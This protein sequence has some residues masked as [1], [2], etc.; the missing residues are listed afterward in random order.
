MVLPAAAV[1]GRRGLA[2]LLALCLW[3]GGPAAAGAGCIPARPL[4]ETR[5]VGKVA[6]RQPADLVLAGGRLLV[7]DDLNARIAVLDQQGR[8]VGSI[9]L[10]RGGSEPALGI[11]F[12]GADE[13][14]VTAPGRGEIVVLDLKG[15]VLRSFGAGEAGRPGRAA[16]I[17]VTRGTCYVTDNETHRVRF[18]ALDGKVLGGWGGLGEGQRQFRAP[19]RMAQD[20]QDRILVTDALNS[21]VQI[22]TPKGD[23][24]AGFGEFGT[25]EGTLFRPAGL[26]V[27]EGDR[28]LVADNY[29]GSLQIFDAGGRYEGVLCGSDGKALALENPV[30]VA[31]RGRTLFVLEMGGGQVSA[32]EIGG[33]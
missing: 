13:I 18:M 2:P 32:F 15:K 23:Y 19:F 22:F 11:G 29:F 10:P 1:A 16:G 25:V 9:P 8:G 5:E 26:A 24:L 20:S 4:F 21:R 33:K 17:L 14:F 3:L 31:A 28:I 30:S 27:L 7:L 6:F 12:G